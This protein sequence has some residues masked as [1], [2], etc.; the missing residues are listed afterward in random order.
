[1]DLIERRQ[2]QVSPS[3]VHGPE[4]RSYCAYQ[5]PSPAAPILVAPQRGVHVSQTSFGR[6]AATGGL[7]LDAVVHGLFD[8]TAVAGNCVGAAPHH[9]AASPPASL[10][11]LGDL[12]AV[13]DELHADTA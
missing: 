12:E 5:S 10:L 1:L 13:D 3:C 11:W 8:V 6:L 4:G 2:S 9:G 7:G